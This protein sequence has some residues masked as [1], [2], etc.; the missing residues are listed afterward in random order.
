MRSVRP[1]A[2]FVWLVLGAMHLPAAVEE[3]VKVLPL[4]DSLTRGNNDINYP[5]GDIPGGYRRAL[6]IALAASGPICDFVGTKDDNAAPDMDPDYEGHPGFRTD[7]IL[8]LTPD[9]LASENPRAVLLLAGTNDILQRVAVETAADNLDLLIET[10]TDADPEIRL[11]VGTILPVTQDWPPFGPSVPAATL[12]ADADAFNVLVRDSVAQYATEGRKVTLV[13][14]NADLVYTD[15]GNPE[16]DFYQPGDGIHPGQAGYDQMGDLWFQALAASDVFTVGPPAAGAPAAPTGLAATV[17]SP[18]RVNLTWTDAA[19]DEDSQEIWMRNLPDGFWNRIHELPADVTARAVTGLKT[20]SGSYSFVC[21]ARNATGASGWSNVV[22]LASSDVAHQK[23]ASA[24]SSLDVQ[25]T[26]ENANDGTEVTHW[27]SEPAANDP[28]ANWTVDLSD[29]HHIQEIRLLARQDADIPEQRRKFEVLAS[30]DPGFASF[31][32]V[33][34][35]GTNPIPHAGSYQTEVDDEPTYRYV[36]V[37]KTEQEELSIASMLVLG[38]EETPTP[39]APTGLTAVAL[40]STHVRLTWQVN[41]DN[42]TGFLVE[43]RL[44]AGIFEE[45]VTTEAEADDFLDSELVADTAYDYRV[46]AVNEGGASAP[47]TVTS[48][49]TGTEAAYD[50][51]VAAYPAFAALPEPDRAPLADP[52]NDG[53]SNLLAYAAAADPLG[54]LT[55]FAVI[56]SGTPGGDVTFRFRRNLAAPDLLYQVLRSDALD[57]EWDP[58]SL[59]SAS[60]EAVAGEPEV[61]MVTLPVPVGDGRMFYRMKIVRTA[62]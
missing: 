25:S 13:D 36:R 41:S 49:T 61:E 20:G 38:V 4:G 3:P 2:W 34:S 23:T 56:E 42:E 21:R 22:T 59:V 6:G 57:G 60:V 51:W 35:Q 62:D 32:V 9:V 12:D 40:D 24:S 43:R 52:N 8:A 48:V 5:N 15:P 45:V 39:S 16:N 44:G 27:V 10:I 54:T 47:T 33:G 46:S 58:V 14:F 26:P 50:S 30:N 17:V 53:A 29:P 7:E 18:S 31:T 11:F 37:A 1:L 28:S 19:G 55:D